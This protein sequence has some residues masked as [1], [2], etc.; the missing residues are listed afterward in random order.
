MAKYTD[1][2]VYSSNLG[3]QKAPKTYQNKLVQFPLNTEP[4]IGMLGF[5]KSQNS[6]SQA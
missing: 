2:S 5:V 1:D 4:L 3:K 6:H